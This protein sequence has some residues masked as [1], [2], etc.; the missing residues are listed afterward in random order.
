M[1]QMINRTTYSLTEAP[2][3]SWIDV[4]DNLVLVHFDEWASNYDFWTEIQSPDLRPV[5]W[6]EYHRR[7]V[8]ERNWLIED[9][10]TNIKFDAPINYKENTGEEFRWENY[11]SRK[12]ASAVPFD[13]FTLDQKNGMTI[14]DFKGNKNQQVL[15]S[16]LNL[17]NTSLK[18]GNLQEY[19]AKN[20]NHLIEKN[21][22]T[23]N[24]STDAPTRGVIILPS[25]IN[26][27]LSIKRN[28]LLE[29]FNL[30]M[31]CLIKSNDQQAI[32]A[33]L[34][35]SNGIKINKKILDSNDL[36]LILVSAYMVLISKV[37]FLIISANL[38]IFSPLSYSVEYSIR[39]HF[40]SKEVDS[41]PDFPIMIESLLCS[42]ETKI[43]INI[44]K[45]QLITH[46]CCTSLFIYSLGT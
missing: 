28:S 32:Y 31:C 44:L 36:V 5:G 27:I 39:Y 1:P 15:T 23:K 6:A 8:K 33:H 16:C 37:F 35:K 26:N 9:D 17:P 14:S 4:R 24:G 12:N 13:I 29:E 7:K 34:F 42:L 21:I 41:T 20:W 11:L 3:Y 40:S 10:L 43:Q 46:F 45:M 25:S 19:I 22:I 30:H 2:I 18:L 38:M